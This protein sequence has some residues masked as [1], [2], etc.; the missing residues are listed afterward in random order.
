MGVPQRRERLFFIAINK[1]IN[2]SKIKLDFNE[3]PIKYEEI[4]DINY[5]PLN[6]DTLTYERW[7]K[8]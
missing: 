2:V 7:K 3:K 5:K 1:N 6:K 8:E 4:K